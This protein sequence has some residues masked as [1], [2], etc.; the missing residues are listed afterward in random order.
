[1]SFIS[2][3]ED[4]EFP[5]LPFYSIKIQKLN[6]N[7]FFVIIFDAPEPSDYYLTRNYCGVMWE[8]M[9]GWGS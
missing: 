2:T 7:I 5:K 1:M 4:C 9:I 8:E 3:H 6:G